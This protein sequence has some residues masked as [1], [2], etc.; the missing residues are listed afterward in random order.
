[1]KMIA[2]PL[3]PNDQVLL[4]TGRVEQW[5]AELTTAIE[6][7]DS[8]ESLI[9]DLME[10][11]EAAALISGVSFEELIGDPATRDAQS[12]D[13]GEPM[14][15]AIVRVLKAAG[16]IPLTRAEMRDELRKDERLAA[17]LE[18]TPNS[19]YNAIKRLMAREKIAKR[20]EKFFVPT[21][22]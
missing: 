3:A 20:G 17:R 6:A 2:S 21:K 16:A 11:L 18:R 4:T 1:M 13:P 22:E 14:T 10:R 15:D 9:S 5:K 8:A 7:R 19:F 12:A